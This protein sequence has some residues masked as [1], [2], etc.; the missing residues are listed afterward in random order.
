MEPSFQVNRKVID[1]LLSTCSKVCN[2]EQNGTINIV[3][4]DDFSIKNLNKKY[5][6][7]DKTTDVLSFHYFSDFNELHEMDIA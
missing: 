2:K 7:I 1:S 6:K 4:L 3:F 5:R